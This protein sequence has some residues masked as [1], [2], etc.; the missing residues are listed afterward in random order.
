LSL[1][2]D[3]EEY[4]L[5]YIDKIA[6]N[7]VNKQL[8]V[9]LFKSMNNS[10]FDKFMNDLRIGNINLSVIAPNGGDVKLSVDNNIKIAK[11]L[12]YEFFQHIDVGGE[13][14]YRTPNTYMVY[15]LPIRRAAQLL[16]KK[17]S[18]PT[19]SKS[20]DLTTGQVTGKSKSS[21][22]TMPEIQILAGLG[23]SDS[24][25]ELM[26][27]RGGNLTQMNAANKLLM[28]QGSVSQKVLDS[29]GGDVVSTKTL[30]AYF[31][32]SHI[33]NNL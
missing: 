24:I 25:K 9:D 4:I 33:D 16:T 18:I 1:R 32:A 10:Q 28:T 8:Y 12:G 17:I 14:P 13:F 22:I 5:K 20:I 6:P 15:R 3:T 30:K 31:I 11:E 2:K 21:K 7:G 23:L 19:D 27:V 29:Y 26:K